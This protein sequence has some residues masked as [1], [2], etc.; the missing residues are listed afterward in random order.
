MTAQIS[1]MPTK[2]DATADRHNFNISIRFD[3]TDFKINFRGAMVKLLFW[4]RVSEAYK[5]L[6]RF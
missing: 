1:H 2:P 3:I 6:D 5:G 4:V